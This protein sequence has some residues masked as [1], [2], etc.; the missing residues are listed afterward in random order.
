MIEMG[1]EFGDAGNT[2]RLARKG[3]FGMVTE[4][5][6]IRVE[7]K[8]WQKIQK[9]K[10]KHQHKVEGFP[11]YIELSFSDFLSWMAEEF[12]KAKG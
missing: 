7:K 8:V 11:I 1:S 3:E 4:Y 6:Q 12:E 10:Q 9:L 2:V 5:K